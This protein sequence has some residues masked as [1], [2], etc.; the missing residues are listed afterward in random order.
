VSDW[1]AEQYLKYQQ[2]RSQPAYD[3]MDMIG[4]R[5]TMRI[6]DLGCGT[7]EHT[8]TLHER[9]RSV[10]T[11]GIDSSDDML[12]KAPRVAGLKFYKADIQEF[13]GDS[14]FDLLVSNAALQ[15]VSGHEELF[16]KFRKALRPGGQIAIQV[17]KNGDHPSQRVAYDLEKEPPYNQYPPCPIDKNTLAP[18]AYASL[19]HRLGFRSIKVRLFVYLHELKSGAETVEWMKGSLLNHYKSTQPP[20]VYSLFEIEFRN[21]VE[22]SI[23]Q[24]KPYLFTFKRILMHAVR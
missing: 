13:D 21:R 15:W 23:G 3:L 18:D 4:P 16:E 10:E 20:E 14:E 5:N 7:G 19:L 24:E 11:I 22:R 6:V 2:E 9:F 17:P 12:S 8:K 1:N